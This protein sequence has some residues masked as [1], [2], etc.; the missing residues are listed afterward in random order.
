[1]KTKN[2]GFTLAEVLVSIVIGVLVL[3]QHLH[4]I[5]ILINHISQ[6]HKKLQLIVLQ[7]M[8]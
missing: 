4:L 7:E 6:F 5:I 3:L 2:S 8:H 1:M